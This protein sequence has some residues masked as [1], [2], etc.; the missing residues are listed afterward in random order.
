MH[1][2][3]KMHTDY[4]AK[5][6]SEN[7]LTRS[8]QEY[9]KKPWIAKVITLYPEMFPGT[10]KFSILGRALREH[11]WSLEIL[12]LREFGIGKHKNVD[13]PPCGGGP[14]MIL[15][16]DVID[17]AIQNATKGI[18]LKKINLP[19]IN[20]S[21]RGYPFT[22]EIAKEFANADGIL[23][24][25]GRFEGVDQ[26]VID[27][28]RMREISLGDFIISGG[29]IAAQA[30][31]DSSVRNL[32]KVLG[33]HLST[34]IESFNDGLLE[35]PQYTRPSDWNGYSVPDV[36]LSGNHQRISNWQTQK[37]IE[38]TK[39]RRPD[40]IAKLKKNPKT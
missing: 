34:K 36:L 20:L 8:N 7:E 31:L 23:I 6:G 14:G 33:N 21:P 24:I 9:T 18:N 13:G 39:D 15:R 12:N 2:R 19:I 25:C 22:N 29:E 27:K 3:T 16:P 17:K 32:P 30:I 35:Y 10:L 38:I 5:H 37:S 11:I 4:D 1:N 28:W 40:L 26:R